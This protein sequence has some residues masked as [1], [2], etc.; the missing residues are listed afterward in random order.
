MAKISDALL[1][2]IVN[3]AEKIEYGSITLTLNASSKNKVDVEFVERRRFTTDDEA[4]RPGR[5][6]RFGPESKTDPVEELRRG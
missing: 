3:R 1:T 5:V 2:E 6:V 4:P